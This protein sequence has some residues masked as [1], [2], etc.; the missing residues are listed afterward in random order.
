MTLKKC[1]IHEA[2]VCVSVCVCVFLT[3]DSSKTIQVI[4]IK[5]GTVTASD[6]R[7]HH[8]LLMT[9]TLTFILGHTGL[10]RGNYKGSII[11]KAV[12]AI[13]IKVAV[14]LV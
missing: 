13:P 9:L 10:N 1:K 14:K 8:I 4:T 7:M 5:L 12:Q 2:K 11:S 6:M 3:S